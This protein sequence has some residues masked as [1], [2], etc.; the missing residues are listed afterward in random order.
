MGMGVEAGHRDRHQY[1]E[2]SSRDGGL[3][4]PL[5]VEMVMNSTAVVVVNNDRVMK[6]TLAPAIAAKWRET[7][8]SKNISR[9]RK[10]KAAVGGE[11]AQA[12][13]QAA[14]DP[15]ALPDALVN[16]DSDELD[17]GDYDDFGAFDL[18]DGDINEGDPDAGAA[19][20]HP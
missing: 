7:L 15:A 17:D 20:Y 1:Q 13:N 10:K 5:C 11:N 18:N 6:R 3:G 2:A 19:P 9:T 8:D 14:P 16:I 12:N 4:V